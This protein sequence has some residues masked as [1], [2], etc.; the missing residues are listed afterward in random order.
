MIEWLIE[1]IEGRKGKQSVKL[2][3]YCSINLFVLKKRW[4]FHFHQHR[5]LTI[6]PSQHRHHHRHYQRLLFH[7]SIC[8]VFQVEIIRNFA[9][10]C[11]TFSMI[12]FSSLEHILSS[13]SGTNINNRQR[14][15]SF[16]SDRL[17]RQIILARQY[18]SPE[19]K[20]K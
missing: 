6:S 13:G 15:C 1:N 8:T 18:V 14:V 19:K 17:F 9:P 20:T 3:R 10:Y 5:H 7:T 4:I 11:V 12:S 2:D 16:T